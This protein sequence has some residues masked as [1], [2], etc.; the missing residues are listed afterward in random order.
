MRAVARRVLF[1]VV[2]ILALLLAVIGLLLPLVPATPFLLLAAWAFSRSSERLHRWLRGLPGFG[3][4][5]A[6]WEENGA[7][8][9]RVKVLATVIL[10]LVAVWPMALIEFPQ[11]LKAVAGATVAGVLLFLWTRPAGPAPRG[12]A[13][14]R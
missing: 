11:W 12:D 8:R 3:P 5:L 7:I 2:G 4:V 9:T 1:L 6:D 10:L 14:E 13:A